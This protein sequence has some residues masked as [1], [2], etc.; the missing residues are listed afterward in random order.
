MHKVN[1]NKLY[2]KL[3]HCIYIYMSSTKRYLCL[4]FLKFTLKATIKRRGN[5]TPKG[6]GW[7][8]K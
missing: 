7:E 6:S 3:F 1:E 2:S 8:Q 5:L 4:Y